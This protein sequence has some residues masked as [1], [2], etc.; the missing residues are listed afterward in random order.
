MHL[1]DVLI[2]GSQSRAWIVYFVLLPLMLPACKED[3]PQGPTEESLEITTYL[4]TVSVPALSLL[5]L[6]W[7]AALGSIDDSIRIEAIN[8]SGFEGS[9]FLMMRPGKSGRFIIRA[10]EIGFEAFHFRLST[11]LSGMRRESAEI[12]IN[13]RTRDIWFTHPTGER[14]YASDD[15]VQLNWS[16][17][18]I[19]PEEMLTLSVRSGENSPWEPLMSVQ[20]GMA[21]L[22]IPATLLRS[23]ASFLR[24]AVGSEEVFAIS[25]KLYVLQQS[26]SEKIV[27]YSPVAGGVYVLHRDV[28]RWRPVAGAAAGISQIEIEFYIG[29][30]L[31]DRRRFPGTQYEIPLMDIMSRVDESGIFGHTFRIRALPDTHAVV[32]SRVE[33]VDFRILTRLENTTLRRGTPLEVRAWH[34]TFLTRVP[35]S[36]GGG[37]RYVD[38]YLTTDGGMTWKNENAFAWQE[39]ASL[40]PSAAANECYLRMEGHA[41]NRLIAD[42]TGPFKI[43]DNT[44]PLWEWKVGDILRYRY[45]ESPWHQK[46]DTL[47]IE[48]IDKREDGDR[49]V[50]TLH[51][52]SSKYDTVAV[53]TITEHKNDMHRLEGWRIPKVNAYRYVDAQLQGYHVE[54]YRGVNIAHRLYTERGYGITMI[55]ERYWYGNPEINIDV[56]LIK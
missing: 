5:E 17:F 55:N 28:F 19:A 31:Y 52:H 13:D 24:L 15:T 43:I 35:E 18:G 46:T 8:H 42:T 33:I 44:A 32:I 30:A 53:E 40:L 49:I 22:T 12:R 7:K 37:K 56:A 27:V 21:S 48:F 3:P 4:D 29:A 50:Y 39:H 14:T 36:D 45:S 20:A 26:G 51:E 38:F 25:P 41:G 16:T 6:E 47:T 9:R 54:W 23:P 2:S 34:S 1:R 10:D 11:I